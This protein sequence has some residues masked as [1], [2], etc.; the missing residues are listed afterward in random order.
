MGLMVLTAPLASA[1]LWEDI[2]WEGGLEDIGDIAYED[3]DPVTPQRIIANLIK[4]GLSFLAIVFLAVVLYGGF[5]WMTAG[6]NEES[7]KKARQLITN[8]TIGVIIIIS[9]YAITVFVLQNT[10]AAT[11]S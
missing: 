7:V 4:I 2:M 9:A 10:I 6:G 11:G 8:G 5:T 1:D 3:I